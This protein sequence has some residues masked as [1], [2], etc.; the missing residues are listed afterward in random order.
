M[1]SN[2]QVHILSSNIKQTSTVTTSSV[3]SSLKSIPIN[4][5]ISSNV[6]LE[7]HTYST[8]SSTDPIQFQYQRSNHQ[9]PH[10][11]QQQQQPANPVIIQ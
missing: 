5:V 1:L 11:Q 4:K 3:S 6:N 7:R 10:Q 8:T 9:Q 2:N